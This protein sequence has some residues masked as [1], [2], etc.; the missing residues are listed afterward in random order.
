[1]R[2]ALN[3]EIDTSRWTSSAYQ[4]QFGQISY[5]VPH[6]QQETAFALSAWGISQ[7]LKALLE[8]YSDSDIKAAAEW[9]T[10]QQ[11]TLVAQMLEQ[12]S[13]ELRLEGAA[14]PPLENLFI[15]IEAEMFLPKGLRMDVTCVTNIV[16]VTHDEED[17]SL[18]KF[19]AVLDPSEARAYILERR[20]TNSVGHH[21]KLH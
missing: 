5:V 10:M 4:I 20:G 14:L 7:G 16:P 21:E 3:P 9:L 15:T 13:Y 8:T 1:L 2:E 12:M 18:Q 17:D 19:V 6:A 11:N